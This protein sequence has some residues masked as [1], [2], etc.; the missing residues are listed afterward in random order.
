M[1]S[2]EDEVNQQFP[3]GYLLK[4][5][6]NFHCTFGI[7]LDI[8]RDNI[9]GVIDCIEF[10]VPEE[11]RIIYSL[12]PRLGTQ[13]E[14]VILG[15]NSSQQ[16]KL[17]LKNTRLQKAYDLLSQGLIKS[18]DLGS[19]RGKMI[20]RFPIGSLVTGT[21]FMLNPSFVTINFS[22][23]CILGEID[24]TEFLD[25]GQIDY[26]FYPL[27]NTEIETVI[28]GYIDDNRLKLSVKPSLLK[29][30]REEKI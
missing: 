5:T 24:F 2:I 12:Y 14:A 8:G 7:I 9:I 21:V 26:S 29:K 25:E 23:D 19:K 1:K 16:I 4:G 3:E 6:V 27:L 30:A 13:I 22:S 28:I 10:P 18:I 17:S 11:G 20:E 15:Y